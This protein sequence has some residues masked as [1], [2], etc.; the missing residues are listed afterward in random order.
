MKQNEQTAAVKCGTC[1]CAFVPELLTQREGEI[2]YTFFR[3]DYCGKAYMVTVTDAALRES[4]GH[5]RALARRNQIRR[6]SE[7][8]QRRMQRL[9]E[10][11]IRRARE[12]RWQYLREDG[13]DGE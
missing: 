10:E 3:C 8:M 11:N 5:Y 7:R 1:G 12:L 9:K 2:E 6:L 4:I 13:Y